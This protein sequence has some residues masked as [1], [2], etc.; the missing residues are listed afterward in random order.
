VIVLSDTSPINYLVLIGHVDILPTLFTQV[1]VP[2]AVVTEL[3]HRG[4]PEAVQRWISQPPAWLLIRTPSHQ[5]DPNLRLGQGEAEAISLAVELHATLLLMDDRRGRQEAEARGLSVAGTL[6]VLAAAAKRELLDLPTAV[7][8][9]RQTNFHI[10]EQIIQ[11]SL[12]ADAA[13]KGKN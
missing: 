3:Q 11:Q 10:A 2:A 4:A 8:R 5:V 6:N 12:K 9:L 1:V 7:A 13:R